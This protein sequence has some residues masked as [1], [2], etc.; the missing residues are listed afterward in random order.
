MML[1]SGMDMGDLIYLVIVVAIAVISVAAKGLGKLLRGGDEEA[2]REDRKRQRQIREDA[3][4]PEQ[5]LEQFF[6]EVKQKRQAPRA[7]AAGPSGSEG[8]QSLDEFFGQMQDGATPAPPAPAARAVPVAAA[9]P[10]RPRRRKRKVPSRPAAA[11]A[12]DPYG[13]DAV[14]KAKATIGRSRKGKR[15]LKVARAAPRPALGAAAARPGS[16]GPRELVQAMIHYEVLGA[17]RALRPYSG[18]PAFS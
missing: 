18:P 5:A 17:P 13:A 14:A 11:P 12:P 7:S 10:E 8:P 9:V 15:R 4:S 16:L 3:P 2:K 1:A 6:Q